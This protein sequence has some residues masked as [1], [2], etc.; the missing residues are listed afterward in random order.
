[1]SINSWQTLVKESQIDVY[2][3]EPSHREGGIWNFTYLEHL[4]LLLLLWKFLAEVGGVEYGAAAMTPG[5]TP[6]LAISINNTIIFLSICPQS[7]ACDCDDW[8][9]SPVR[10]WSLISEDGF[11]LFV[12]VP[13]ARYPLHRGTLGFDLVVIGLKRL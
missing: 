4:S 10:W 13:N 7:S 8:W 11:L 12:C 1:M 9:L 6:N 5:K 2:N 3:E